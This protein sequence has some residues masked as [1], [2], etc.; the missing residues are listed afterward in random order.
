[1]ARARY[2]V[3]FRKWRDLYKVLCFDQLSECNSGVVLQAGKCGQILMRIKQLN[4]SG[5]TT[6]PTR[7]ENVRFWGH[8]PKTFGRLLLGVTLIVCSSNS[9]A[10]CERE[11]GILAEDLADVKLNS[12]QSQIIA[13]KLALAR[14]HCWVQHEQEAMALINSARKVAG[15]KE[16]TGEFDWENV[17]LESLEQS[18]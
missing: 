4:N 10:G 3:T 6:E 16:T 7:N 1:M 2:L 12:A 9:H 17:P 5:H 8:L 11:F 18:P 14:R 13:N 15:L